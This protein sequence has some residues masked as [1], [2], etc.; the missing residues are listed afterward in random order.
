MPDNLVEP[1]A[2]ADT[3][4]PA[5]VESTTGEATPTQTEGPQ[6]SEKLLKI[7][8]MQALFAGAPPALSANVK[9]FTAKSRDEA[10]VIKD[11]IPALQAAGMGFYKSLS[12]QLGVI[13]NTLHVHVEDLQAADKAGK[14]QQL[15]PPFDQINHAVSKSGLRNP[16]LQITK[17]PGGRKA[18]HPKSPPQI[19]PGMASGTSGVPLSTPPA[20]SMPMPGPAPSVQ[21]KL[22]SARVMNLS[23]GSPTSGP[24]PGAGRFLNQV[25]KPVV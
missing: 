21:R 16:A 18:P 25:L 14:L 20:G 10:K 11:N 24:S 1:A 2:D 3:M 22:A 9:D 7:P 4:A 15:A 6:L 5:P 8:A 17:V 19:S 23:P 13:Y 12:G